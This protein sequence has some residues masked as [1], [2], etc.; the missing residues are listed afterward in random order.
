MGAEDLG[1]FKCLDYAVNLFWIEAHQQCEEIGGFLAEPQ[2]ARSEDFLPIHAK[3]YSNFIQITYLFTST[4]LMIERVYP[5]LLVL[6]LVVLF[7]KQTQV[8]RPD[9]L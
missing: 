6:C 2:T 7:P 4:V 9:F 5:S 1:C 8:L 3:F